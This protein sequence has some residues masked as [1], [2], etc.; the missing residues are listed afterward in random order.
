MQ[1]LTQIPG[2]AG[3]PNSS[4]IRLPSLGPA[5]PKLSS[6]SFPLR[7]TPSINISPQINPAIFAIPAVSP[8]SVVHSVPLAP[9]TNSLPMLSQGPIQL[10]N[11][12]Q[13]TPEIR[14]M[15]QSPKIDTI[16][17]PPSSNVQFVQPG[18]SNQDVE[19]KLLDLGYISFRNIKLR[20]GDQLEAKYILATD[21][22]GNMVLIYLNID[23]NIMVKPSDLTTMES[24]NSVSIP[25]AI[26]VGIHSAAGN[27]IA[28]TAYLCD[29]GMCVMLTDPVSL[30]PTDNHLTFVEKPA[31]KIAYIDD[32]PVA[33]PVVR[34]GDIL[35]NPTLVNEIVAESTLN[36]RDKSIPLFKKDIEDTDKLST[37]SSNDIKTNMMALGRAMNDVL[38][39]LVHFERDRKFYDLNPPTTKEAINRYNIIV[40]NIKKR[41]NMFRTLMKKSQDLEKQRSKLDE[42]I[43]DMNTNMNDLNTNYYGIDKKIFTS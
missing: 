12:L 27:K 28:G 35:E 26:R 37:K 4:P 23:S 19:K 29:N 25:Y 17:R 42:I 30:K 15:V 7:D 21:H 24:A 34:M 2:F 6:L 32:S 16:L 8:V 9:A 20:K 40:L 43:R 22:R 39:S 14:P 13:V 5:P 31:D 1:S 18:L 10:S 36:I 11:G 33:V 41:Q 38:T 3:S